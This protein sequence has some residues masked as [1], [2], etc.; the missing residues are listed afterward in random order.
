[1]TIHLLKLHTKT[2]RPRLLWEIYANIVGEILYMNEEDHVTCMV[3]EGSN[4][5]PGIDKN[6][7]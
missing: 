4:E 2:R 7:H 3:H 1:M 5:L 6:H